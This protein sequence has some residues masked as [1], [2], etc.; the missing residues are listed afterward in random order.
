LKNHIFLHSKFLAKI[1]MIEILVEDSRCT[2]HYVKTNLSERNRTIEVMT[3]DSTSRSQ[4]RER[5]VPARA[6]LGVWP[7]CASAP[8]LGQLLPSF[9]HE[10]ASSISM[11]Q[12][13]RFYFKIHQLV[14]SMHA[15]ITMHPCMKVA[16]MQ[17]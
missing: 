11:R 1:F 13:A 9:H 12:L 8:A 17:V 4:P 7:S 5:E 15:L 14:H 16:Q 10:R 2:Y 3:H 6:I